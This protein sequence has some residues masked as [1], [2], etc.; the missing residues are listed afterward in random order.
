MIKISGLSRISTAK[1]IGETAYEW[2]SLK[3]N[4]NGGYTLWEDSNPFTQISINRIRNLKGKIINED[5]EVEIV[6]E[7]FAIIRINGTGIV[8]SKVV[9]LVKIS[10]SIVIRKEN[11]RTFL[12]MEGD[13]NSCILTVE[14]PGEGVLEEVA[15]FKLEKVS[16]PEA[17]RIRT[18]EYKARNKKDSPIDLNTFNK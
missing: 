5:N 16:G 13:S 10:D 7:A 12:H 18:Q 15:R 6:N 14:T 3:P 2:S 8:M 4:L 11:N 17:D 1:E 9:G